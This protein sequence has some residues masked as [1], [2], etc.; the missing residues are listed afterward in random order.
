MSAAATPG[1]RGDGCGGSTGT[2]DGV[3]RE[4]NKR[5]KES[6]GTMQLLDRLGYGLVSLSSS[7]GAIEEGKREGLY[8]N[9]HKNE[10]PTDEE[11][12]SA[13]VSDMDPTVTGTLTIVF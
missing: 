1:S 13:P 3:G 11:S 7:P 12:Y 2:L 5:E 10:E 8:H 9:A 4:R 6:S